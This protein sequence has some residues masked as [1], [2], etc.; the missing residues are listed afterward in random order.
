MAVDDHG[1]EAL[2]KAAE[3]VTPGDKSNYLFKVKDAA[4][5]TL[6]EAILIASGG[7]PPAL[8]SE[9]IDHSG[10]QDTS[11]DEIIPENEDRTYL[12]IQNLE[13]S[14]A[15]VL[16]INFG[17]TVSTTDP[18]SYRIGPG[19]VF[20]LGVGSFISTQAVNAISSSGSIKFTAKEG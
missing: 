10:S 5:I 20:E 11:A 9:F 13:T 19:E 6:L 3:Q 7:S 4:V 17:D 16:F 8:N 12:R 1:L 2:K 14:P 15:K 18:G